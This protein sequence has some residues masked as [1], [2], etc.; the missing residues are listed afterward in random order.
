MEE[1]ALL[2]RLLDAGVALLETRDE[3]SGLGLGDGGIVGFTMEEEAGAVTDGA[4]MDG[5][6]CSCFIA[7]EASPILGIFRGGC[8]SGGEGTCPILPFGGCCSELVPEDPV[9]SAPD[10]PGGEALAALMARSAMARFITRFMI[11][12]ISSGG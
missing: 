5:G 7:D 8:P 11:P 2:G 1:L 3:A 9:K 4:T 6:D 12:L 10:V